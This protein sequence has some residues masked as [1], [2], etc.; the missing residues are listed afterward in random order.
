MENRAEWVGWMV[1]ISPATTA[2]SIFQPKFDYFDS[3]FLHL[4]SSQL[5]PNFVKHVVRT[6]RKHLD[7]IMGVVCVNA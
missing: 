3:I 1:K 4:E 7:Y 2:T 6:E 5:N